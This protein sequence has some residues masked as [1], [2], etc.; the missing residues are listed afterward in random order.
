MAET[1]DV[2]AIIKAGNRYFS[3]KKHVE[4]LENGC[5]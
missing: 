3:A 5:G 2:L 1:S 4:V